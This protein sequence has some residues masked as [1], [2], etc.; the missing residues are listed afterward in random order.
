MMGV[1]FFYIKKCHDVGVFDLD[2]MTFISRRPFLKDGI[3]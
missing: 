1:L 2:I 3:F